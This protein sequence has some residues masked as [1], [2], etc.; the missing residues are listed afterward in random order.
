MNVGLNSFVVCLVAIMIPFYG[1]G[2]QQLR[3]NSL[4]NNIVFGGDFIIYKGERINLDS[5]NF[6]ID[7]QLTGDEVKRYRYAFNSVN[8]AVSYLSNGS[9]A[10]PMTLFIAPW[11]YWIDNP[12][13]PEIRVPETIGGAPV[14]LKIE[15]EWLKFFGLSDNPRDVVLACNRGQTMGAKGNFTMLSITGNG[16]RAENITFGNYCNIDLE[17]GPNPA[18]NRKKRGSAIVQAQLVFA[19]GDKIYARNTHFVSRLN[20]CPFSGGKRTLFD[21]CHFES[22]DDALAPTGV[23]LN[24]T[25]DIYSSKPFYNTS[26]TGAVLL[27][28]SINSFTRG[29]QYWAKSGGQIC[30]VDSRMTANDNTYWGWREVPDLNSKYYY[31]NNFVNGKYSVIGE[32]HPYAT[33]DLKNKRLL[34]AYRFNFNDSVVYNIYNL[35]CGDDDWDPL[36]LK[37]TVREVELKDKKSY[38]NLPTQLIVSASSNTIETGKGNITLSARAYRFGNYETQCPPLKWSVDS[39]D[40]LLIQ[41]IPH[42]D[43]TCSVVSLSNENET[44]NVVVNARSDYGLEGSVVISVSPS[45][46]EAPEFGSMPKLELREGVLMLDYSLQTQFDDWSVVNWYRCIDAQGSNPVEVAVSRF[47][48]P[49]GRYA[50]SIGDVGWFIMAKISPRHSRSVAGDWLHV[51]TGNPIREVDVV[52]N[53]GVMSV[54]LRNLA[55]G[56]QPVVKPGFFT[57]DCFAPADTK[58]HDWMANSGVDPWYYGAG[59]DGASKDSGLVQNVQGARL[60][61]TPVGKEFGNMK[62]SFTAVPA[63]TAGQGFSSARQQYMDIF[64]KFDTYTLSGYALR[65]IRTT[66]YGN[67]IDFIIMKYSNGVAT[68]ISEPVSADCFRPDCNFVLEVKG[69]KFF[70][71]VW[72]NRQYH[73]VANRDEVKQVVDMVAQISDNNFGGFGF[74]HTGTVGGGATLIKD[75]TIEWK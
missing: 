65:L 14:G 69:N 59:I 13:D 32:K 43:N 28:C 56:T 64:I 58:E 15:C 36:H 75:L 7:G 20:L 72:N 74:Q 62:I 55:T 10:E 12:D 29:N 71:H 4:N 1:I 42:E 22:T 63:K 54:N 47:N 9:E 26:G 40:S 60:R 25:F 48:E 50:L 61:Y 27:N 45:I 16:T 41:L 35:L 57:M 67:A 18:L 39:S 33:I 23:Y 2:A 38:S 52:G 3:V 70:V 46:L 34:D 8:E 44:R 5:K 73:V 49:C 68:A 17:Y 24:S 37:P 6:F 66:K 21:H 51:T 31:H 11:V 53:T 19:F 30:V